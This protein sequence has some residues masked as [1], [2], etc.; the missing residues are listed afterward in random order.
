MIE[1]VLGLAALTVIGIVKV[2]VDNVDARVR[3]AAI[4]AELE[5]IRFEREKARLDHE[6]DA[7]IDALVVELW[8][9]KAEAEGWISPRPRDQ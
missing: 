9:K 2:I 1:L 3:L 7:Q 5:D 8:A 4:M 6:I